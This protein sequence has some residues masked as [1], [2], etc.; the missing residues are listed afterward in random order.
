[1]VTFQIPCQREKGIRAWD[2]L[3]TCKEH[4]P[5][6]VP[7]GDWQLRSEVQGVDSHFGNYAGKRLRLAAA[8][9]RVGHAETAAGAIGICNSILAFTGGSLSPISHLGCD[10]CSLSPD[11]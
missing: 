1:M 8:K 2:A 3:N 10:K 6:C 7:T 9:S 5:Y 4:L 11:K